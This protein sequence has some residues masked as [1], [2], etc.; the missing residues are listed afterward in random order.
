M[1]L[2]WIVTTVV[3]IALVLLPIY[4]K[5]GLDYPFYIDNILI[6]ILAITFCRYIFLLKHHWLASAKWI[7]ILFIFLPIP[8]LFFL[9]GAFYDFQAYSDEEGLLSMMTS[10]PFEDQTGLAKYVRAEMLL[11]WAAALLATLFMPIRMIVSLYREMKFG[12]H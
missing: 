11:F 3:I 10:L 6:I 12:T 8:I 4:T 2:T 9:T 1:E 5:I 7:K